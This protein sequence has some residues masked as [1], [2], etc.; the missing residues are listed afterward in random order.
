MIIRLFKLRKIGHGGLKMLPR[1]LVAQVM[2]VGVF[3]ASLIL[4]YAVSLGLAFVYGYVDLKINFKEAAEGVI[5][6]DEEIIKIV[7]ESPAIIEIYDA[8]GELG[9]VLAKRDLRK[10]DKLTNYE[11][12]VLPLLI[13]FAG[14]NAEGGSFFVPSTNS[15]VYTNFSKNRTDKIIIELAFNYL[16][17]NPNPL[18]ASAF[19]R[20]QKPPVTYLDDQAYAPF[21]KKK[22][23]EKNAKALDDFKATISSNE[24]IVSECK[25]IDAANVR[26]IAEQEGDYQKNCIVEVNYSNCSEFRQQIN[27]NKSLSQE[28][29]NTCQENKATLASQYKE[30]EELKADME[31]EASNTLEEQKGELS[32]GT[33][34]PD[35]QSIYMRLVPDQ[36]AFHY[37]R[38][39]LHELFH[40]YSTGGSDLPIFIDEGITD[41]VTSKSFKLSDYEIA[42]VSGYFKEAQV[43]MALSEK[44]PEQEIM[45]AYFTSNTE[46]L[47]TSF[48]KAF[49]GVSYETFL[50]KGDTMYR[51]TYE[52]TGPTFDLGFWDTQIDHPA[53]QDMRIFLGLEPKKFKQ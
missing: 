46:M 11:G 15:V 30:F 7:Q 32:I 19:E 5:T 48:K 52:V 36:D 28:A 24:K 49:P 33:Y 38:V 25:A 12:I 45:T 18:A 51:E 29:T 14:G 8:S 13:K 47:E 27:E 26:L 31:K 37:L 2:G 39:L 44:I 10:K 9:V 42:E 34:S 22:R 41:Y 4:I 43:F 1:F 21:M 20:S 16:K 50:S 23:S 3:F 6:K 40:H 35:T 17:H 53:V